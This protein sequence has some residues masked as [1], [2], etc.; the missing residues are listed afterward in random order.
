MFYKYKVTW[1][2]SY[3]D[4]ESGE[5]GITWA[6]SYG[7]AAEAVIKDYGKDS[8]INMALSEIIL[9]SVRCLNEDEIK[10]ALECD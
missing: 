8:V 7:D 10:H 2:D 3:S 9:D 6:S 1:Y 4:Q 5:G